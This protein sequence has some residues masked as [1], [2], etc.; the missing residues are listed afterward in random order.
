MSQK[1]LLAGAT[2]NL[3]GKIAQA[4]VA[5][6]AHVRVL[7]RPSSDATKIVALQQL[8]VE[9]IQLEMSNAAALQQACAGIDCVV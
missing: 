3:G 1:I 9:V 2:G 4:L 8:G 7:V 5:R 6:G